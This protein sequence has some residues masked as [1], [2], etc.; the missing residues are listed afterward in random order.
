MDY[1]LLGIDLSDRAYRIEEIP[2]ETIRKYVGGRGLGSFL[3][4]KLVPARMDPLGEGNHLIFTA[5]PASGTKFPNS[6]KTNLTTKSPLTGVYLYSVASGILAEQMR[7]AGFWAIDITGKA[8]SPVLIVVHNREVEFR[9]AKQLWGMETAAA[10]RAMLASVDAKNAATVAIGPAG[11]RLISSAGVFGEGEL[12]RCFG[13]GGAGSVMGSK[14][15]KG[16]VVSGDGEV[17]IPDPEKLGELRRRIGRTLKTDWREWAE[18]W[19]R[20]ETASDLGLENEMGML[21]TRNWKQ[22]QF[23]GWRRISKSTAS[24][25]W[26]DKNRSCAPYCL[27]PGC[28]QVEVLTGPYK[29]ARSDFEYETIYAFGSNCGVDKM[30]AIVAASQLCD[31]FGVDTITTGV[32]IGFAMECFEEGLIGTEETDGIDLRFGND[33]AMI[34]ALKKIV[35]QEGF[36]KELA[37]GTRRLSEQI[38]GSEA[39]AMHSKGMELGGYE[40]RGLNGQALQFAI[41]SVG[42]CHHA[43]GLPAR[44]EIA[45]GTGRN[46]EGKGNYVRHGGLERIIRDSLIVCTFLSIGPPEKH[47][48]GNGIIIEALSALFGESWTMDD[49]DQVG[50]RVMCQERQFNARE[51]LTRRDDLLPSRLSKEP[52]PDGPNRGEIVPLEKL[53]DDFYRIMGY[54]LSSGNPSDSLLKELG[55]EK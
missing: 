52:K 29:G 53:K 4:Y 6:S 33:E 20:Y 30:E 51:G 7:R 2:N 18:E 21:P 42:G 13:R 50:R 54:D 32:T 35:N 28:H 9:D 49:V 17:E 37:K 55:I 46:I 41:S 16:M 12:Y 11:E 44:A 22:G 39:F 36:G 8:D 1:L 38:K 26:P 15:L 48:I 24:M 40:C 34:G 45:D 23:E 19:R 5:G 10:Q 31:E 27:T 25:G 43:Y 14:N 3:L 47:V